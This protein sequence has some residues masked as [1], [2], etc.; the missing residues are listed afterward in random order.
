MC[1][2]AHLFLE[3]S[4]PGHHVIPVLDVAGLEGAVPVRDDPV[5]DDH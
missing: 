5:P 2:Q 4:R 1:G 3:S